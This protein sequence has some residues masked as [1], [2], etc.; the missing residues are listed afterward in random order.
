MASAS[1][2]S[3]NEPARSPFFHAVKLKHIIKAQISGKLVT[4]DI[5][6]VAIASVQS[7]KTRLKKM[8]MII[9]MNKSHECRF[10]ADARN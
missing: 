6:D 10:L 1:T 2:P 7:E 4:S 5:K 9:I 8:I 3:V